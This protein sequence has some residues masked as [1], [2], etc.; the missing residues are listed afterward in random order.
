M[1][2]T[3][4]AALLKR[5]AHFDD[6]DAFTEILHRHADLVRGVCV[7]VA[8]PALA[9]DAFQATFIALSRRAGS[10]ADHANVAGWLHRAACRIS[11]GLRREAARRHAREARAATE[12]RRARSA[13][14]A[15]AAR[16]GIL[17][18][19]LDVAIGCLPER[20]RIPVVLH[21][22]EGLS[23]GEMSRRLGV[24]E[25]TLAQQLSR[26]RKRLHRRLGGGAE[27]SL[28]VVAAFPCPANARARAAR[29]ARQPGS[30]SAHLTHASTFAEPFAR[31]ALLAAL[32]I[33][34]VIA[35][36]LTIATA[37]EA[38]SLRH[39]AA[40]MAAIASSRYGGA[41]PPALHRQAA[42][43]VPASTPPA[44]PPDW[45]MAVAWDRSPLN[46]YPIDSMGQ[47]EGIRPRVA[48]ASAPALTD[49]WAR[50]GSWPRRAGSPQPVRAGGW[51]AGVPRVGPDDPL[52]HLDDGNALAGARPQDHLFVLLTA[53]GAGDVVLA[54]QI[55]FGVDGKLTIVMDR[56]MDLASERSGE[57]RRHAL[58]VDLGTQNG[59]QLRLRLV[60]RIFTSDKGPNDYAW[61]GTCYTQ[62]QVDV[63]PAS[64]PMRVRW[65]DAGRCQGMPLG[66]S[67]RCRRLQQSASVQWSSG[68]GGTSDATANWSGI[69]RERD[70]L[71]L[72]MRE[73]LPAHMPALAHLPGEPCDLVLVGPCIPLGGHLALYDCADIATD[74]AVC[75]QF[76]WDRQAG[77]PVM[78]RIIV[79]A[80][81]RDDP[82]ASP[83]SSARLQLYVSLALDAKRS[84][85]A[86]SIT[87]PG[88]T[89]W[90]PTDV[91]LAWL[92]DREREMNRMP[93]S[94]A[95]RA[96]PAHDF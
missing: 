3:A 95:S 57:L 47:A 48:D 81:P 94:P 88:L 42:A 24:A 38:R 74:P 62:V 54:P 14:D 7:R 34:L 56:Y 52:W 29:Y 37:A 60:A 40:P 35:I 1:D 20:Y 21:Y 23:L 89:G 22:L 13:Q 17:D 5:F 16:S 65:S 93:A 4:D 43:D 75:T 36:A 64:A 70:A 12:E 90:R 82:Q 58:L 26:A 50:I 6:D 28:A 73:R 71:P 76:W 25:M 92:L 44:G 91:S 80:I 32:V 33:A 46:F 9:D 78:R 61:T 18:D 2:L 51:N 86:T 83:P 31:S 27:G 59:G 41:G 68:D 30:E 10:L 96:T 79:M 45:V 87:M 67:G 63:G 39:A 55:V 72:L 49:T 15:P 69:L 84:A 66:R 11:R 85:L 19:A 77:E 8:G 53:E